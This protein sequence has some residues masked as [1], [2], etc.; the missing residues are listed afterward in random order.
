[1]G[2]N[3]PMTAHCTWNDRDVPVPRESMIHNECQQIKKQTYGHYRRDTLV[4]MNC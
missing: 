3:E 4:K 1:M 2:V